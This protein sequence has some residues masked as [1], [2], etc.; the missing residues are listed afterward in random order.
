MPARDAVGSFAIDGDGDQVSSV[1]AKIAR[2]LAAA[3]VLVPLRRV[4]LGRA[5]K[6]GRH[7]QF[8][9]GHVSS[10]LLVRDFNLDLARLGDLFLQQRDR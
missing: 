8:H 7:G 5:Q 2:A 3:N 1:L 6:K 4:P 9:S 10:R